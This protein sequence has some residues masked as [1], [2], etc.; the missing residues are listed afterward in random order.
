[1]PWQVVG[2]LEGSKARGGYGARLFAI[3]A[4][5]RPEAVFHEL[6]VVRR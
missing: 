4:P 5:E 3:E 6:V 1:M 2:S